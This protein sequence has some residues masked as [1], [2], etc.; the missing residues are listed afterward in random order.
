MNKFYESSENVGYVYP[1]KMYF[2]DATLTFIA[3]IKEV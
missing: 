1:V 3:N 2:F